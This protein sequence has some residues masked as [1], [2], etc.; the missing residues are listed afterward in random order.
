[1]PRCGS[2]FPLKIGHFLTNEDYS[3]VNLP[4][5]NR[6]EGTLIRRHPGFL[7]ASAALKER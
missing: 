3:V 4:V 6:P 2:D 7:A 1:M 5:P